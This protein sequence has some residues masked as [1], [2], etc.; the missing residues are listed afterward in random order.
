MIIKRFLGCTNHEWM[1][2]LYLGHG[3]ISP[4]YYLILGVTVGTDKLI[5]IFRPH[6]IAYLHTY[7]KHM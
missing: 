7:N 1:R 2:H 4:N 6:K 5:D 3:R